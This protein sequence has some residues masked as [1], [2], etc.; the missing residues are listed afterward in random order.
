MS[1]SRQLQPRNSEISE[2]S[3][4]T[5]PWEGAD[6]ESQTTSQ[7]KGKG[8]GKD[9]GQL[10][11]AW[12]SQAGASIVT[13]QPPTTSQQQPGSLPF[14]PKFGESASRQGKGK[15]IGSHRARP[16]ASDD[17]QYAAKRLRADSEILDES[18]D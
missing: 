10:E 17:S 18:S 6:S 15:G 14:F 5:L 4:E 3:Q 7:A 11:I 8:K 16:S 13:D 12:S 2:A 1:S 9:K